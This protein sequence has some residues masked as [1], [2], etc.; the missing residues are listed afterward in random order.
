MNVKM[1]SLLLFFVFVLI[2]LEETVSVETLKRSVVQRKKTITQTILVGFV[3]T[4]KI[5]LDISQQTGWQIV[6]LLL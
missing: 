1:F 3:D 4:M 6:F 2:Q 5:F